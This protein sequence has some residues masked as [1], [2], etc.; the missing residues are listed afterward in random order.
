MPIVNAGVPP[1]KTADEAEL[2]RAYREAREAYEEDMWVREKNLQASYKNTNLQNIQDS[3]TVN[4]RLGMKLNKISDLV[5]KIKSAYKDSF[6]SGLNVNDENFTKQLDASIEK[7]TLVSGGPKAV[8]MTALLNDFLH[9]EK[10]S[11]STV[12][13]HRMQ[14]GFQPPHSH[15]KYRYS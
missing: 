1:E 2:L 6:F 11:R 14:K 8:L 13:R 7:E 9:R 10:D 3:D 12:Y 4:D 15:R 5:R